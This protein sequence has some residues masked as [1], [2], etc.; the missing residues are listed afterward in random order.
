MVCNWYKRSIDIEIT[1]AFA[2]VAPDR[3]CSIRCRDDLHVFT[4]TELAVTKTNGCKIHRL[5]GDR[6]LGNKCFP[7]VKAKGGIVIDNGICF[8]GSTVIPADR[9]HSAV[10]D[11]H[12]GPVLMHFKSA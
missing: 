12:R 5:C 8:I 9:D 3:N 7:S 2:T 4:Y 10:V 1:G 11:R 6:L